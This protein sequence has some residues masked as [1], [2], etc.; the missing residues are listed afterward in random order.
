MAA[1]YAL[2]H[3]DDTPYWKHCLN[4]TWDSSLVNLEP[5]ILYGFYEFARQRNLDF[6]FPFNAGF[7]CIAAGMNWSPTDKTSLL[8]HN[9]LKSSEL[10]KEFKSC[11]NRLNERKELC[12][13]LIKKKS[14]LFTILKNVHK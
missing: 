12:K 8:I 10:E 6:K 5:S 7:H 11:I 9:Y 14:S 4:K 1:H 13:N 2:S 3:R